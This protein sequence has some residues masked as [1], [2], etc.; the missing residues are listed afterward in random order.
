MGDVG[1]PITRSLGGGFNDFL[2]VHPY[3]GEM[4]QF[5]E[6]MLE[7][8]LKPPTGLGFDKV[9]LREANG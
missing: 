3:L 4:I 7:M 8:G 2:N 9:L 5:D 6:H 1:F